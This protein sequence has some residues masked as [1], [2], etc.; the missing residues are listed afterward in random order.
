M[1][2]SHRYQEEEQERREAL[3][4]QKREEDEER[5]RQKLEEEAN[6]RDKLIKNVQQLE[7][8]K[9]EIQRE[10]LLRSL[11]SSSGTQLKSAVVIPQTKTKSGNP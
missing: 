9:L 7:H 4:R 10:L 1:I 8:R 6:L 2:V 5:R 3:E 11:S